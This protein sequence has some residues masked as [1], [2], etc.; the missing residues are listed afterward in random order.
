MIDLVI[1]DFDGVVID[2][3]LI[4]NGVLAEV[5]T[6]LGHPMAV[7][8][9][10]GYFGGTT[11]D[12]Q[13]AKLETL[14]SR[15]L[16]P[17]F[18]QSLRQ[19]TLDGLASVR[20]IPGVEAFLAWLGE[21]PVCIG[22]TSALERIEHCLAAI[23]LTQHFAGNVFSVAMVQRNKPAPDI[24]LY[25]AKAMGARPERTIVIEDSPHGVQ[26]GLDAG[27]TVIGL[28]AA[29]HLEAAHAGRLREAGAHAV[30]T[31]YGEVRH[32]LERMQK[33]I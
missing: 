22:S 5:A 1:F 9:A 20:P 18:G 23:G 10:L 4:A 8:D 29:S 26:A 16:G 30:A 24:F 6:E 25:A 17:A 15:P 28:A 7:E 32:H 3:E 14:V 31:S 33:R 19:R 2:S 11:L 13:V 27:M 12:Q 21:T